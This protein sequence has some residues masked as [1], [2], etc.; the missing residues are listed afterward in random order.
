MDGHNILL[1][2]LYGKD[3]GWQNPQ[4]EYPDGSYAIFR[5]SDDCLEV[6]SD[7]AASRT[8]WYC[9]DD[10]Y[11]VASTS[12]RAIIMFLGSLEFNDQVIPWMLSTGS[13]GPDS[14]WDKRIR[15]LPPDSSVVLDKGRWSI[16]VNRRPVVFS[17]KSRSHS[18]HRELLTD[19]IRAVIQSL[20]RSGHINFD[21]Y[22]LPLSG[23]YD[24]RAILCFLT[25]RG[26]PENLK[27]ITWGLEQNADRKGNDAAV[28]REL[29]SKLGVKHRYF[30]TD[31]GSE[32]MEKVIDRFIRCGEGR[33]DHVSAYMDGLETWRKLLEEEGCSGIIRGDE[34][35]GWIPVSSELTVRFN[36]GMGLCADYRN[37]DGIVEKFGFPR[38]DLPAELRRRKDETLSAWRDR[39]YHAYR[40]PT[41]LAALSDIKYSYV[42]IINPL[43]ARSIL[44]RV[45]EL[46]DSLR[47]RKA[48]F[49]EIV[50]S[51]GPNLPY[52]T[53]DANENLNSLLGKKQIVE[54]VRNKIQSEEAKRIFSRDFLEHVLR[55]IRDEDASS[56]ESTKK[57]WRNI[58]S[59][60]PRSV[61]NWIRDRVAKPSLDG[62]AL[63]FRVF[64][65][66]R[67]HELLSSD[68]AAAPAAEAAASKARLDSRIAS[69]R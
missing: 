15:R 28:A 46:P 66:I 39:L 9:F 63:A 62:N 21:D 11:F 17:P 34:G 32:S 42:E 56:K 51:I 27:A 25:E 19:E 8:L 29:A 2:C 61:K 50:D 45:R 58:K 14:S 33:I 24:S 54:L 68:C 55:C 65:I 13:L 67:M 7:A 20:K 18:S 64:L 41:I 36:V 10:E 26:A 4:K 49:K 12:Q 69:V 48:L 35:F 30:H 23:G 47:T 6:V 59:L 53:E 40:L 43:L 37:L 3:E 44:H 60:V 1:G 16:T 31:V 38:Q 22:L 52:A 57:A 5:N